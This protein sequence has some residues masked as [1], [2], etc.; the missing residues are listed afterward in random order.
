MNKIE[1]TMTGSVPLMI[2]SD[3]S[4]NPLRPAQQ[5]RAKQSR[6]KQRVATPLD[7]ALET[8]SFLV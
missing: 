3:H 5:S 1:F 6:A 4:A 8:V 2:S 7:Q